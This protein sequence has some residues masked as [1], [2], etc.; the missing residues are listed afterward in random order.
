MPARPE[1]RRRPVPLDETLAYYMPVRPR[2]RPT[3]DLSALELMYA[4]YTA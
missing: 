3:R 1:S 4:Y 2:A